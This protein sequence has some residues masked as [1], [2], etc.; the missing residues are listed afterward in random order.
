MQNKYNIYEINTQLKLTGKNKMFQA[1]DFE[2]PGNSA[3]I[4][5][6]NHIKEFTSQVCPNV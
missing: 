2:V 5:T 6:F 1:A 3:H 4:S